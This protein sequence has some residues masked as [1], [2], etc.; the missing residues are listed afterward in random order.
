MAITALSYQVGYQPAQATVQA[1]VQAAGQELTQPTPTNPVMLPVA[2]A[3]SVVASNTVASNTATSNT[4]TSN[5]VASNQATLLTKENPQ[6]AS[7]IGAAHPTTGSAQIVEIGAQRYLEF[8]QDFSSNAGPDLFVLL[9]TEAVPESYSPENYV[10]LG[11]LA[12]TSGTQRYVIPADVDIR[13]FQ[14]AVIWC[15]QFDVTFGFATL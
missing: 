12:S 14:S 1:T 7:F 5:T 6:G 8:D 9:H 10:I 3:P 11:R 2:T 13:T 4:A 15:R